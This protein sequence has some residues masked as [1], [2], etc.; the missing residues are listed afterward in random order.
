MLDG[1][2]ELAVAGRPALVGEAEPVGGGLGAPVELRIVGLG[3]VHE[4]AVV[5][6][7]Q[8]QELGMPV[9]AEAGQDDRLELAGQEVGQV[10]RADLLVLG[11]PYAAAP[12]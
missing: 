3:Q 5:A 9:E 1:R 2:C 8:R 7:V 11:G 6:E 12:A 4:P 10:E